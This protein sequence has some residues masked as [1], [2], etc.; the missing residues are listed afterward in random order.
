M[1]KL[2]FPLLLLS[3]LLAGTA[4][5]QSEPG[6]DPKILVMAAIFNVLAGFV[7]V[8]PVAWAKNLLEKWGL[9]ADLIGKITP[10]ISGV[11][12]VLSAIGLSYAFGLRVLEDTDLWSQVVAGL[13]IN[14]TSSQVFYELFKKWFKKT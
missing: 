1:K 5:A 4:F 7:I 3:L 14:Q 8:W 10:L 6:G 12:G 11:L 9:S 2:A 13:G